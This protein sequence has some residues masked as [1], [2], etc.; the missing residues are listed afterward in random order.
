ML[1]TNFAL[2][3]T[4]TMYDFLPSTEKNRCCQAEYGTENA[5]NYLGLF[6]PVVQLGFSL[7][8]AE[9]ARVHCCG[10]LI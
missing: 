5:V 7:R 4:S 2:I 3:H 9:E 10:A 8:N 6:G 1:L